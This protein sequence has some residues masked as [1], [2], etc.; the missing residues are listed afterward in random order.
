[1]LTGVTQASMVSRFPYVPTRI[2]HSVADLADD[3]DFA[4]GTTVCL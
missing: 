2:V 1:V 4:V 3:L